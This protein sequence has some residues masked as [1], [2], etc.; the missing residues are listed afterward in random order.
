MLA[1][2]LVLL[3]LSVNLDVCLSFPAAFDSLYSDHGPGP[4]WNQSCGPCDPDLCPPTRGC[5]AGLVL[6]RC[7][8][9]EECGNREGQS[10]DPEHRGGLHGLC[11]SGLRCQADPGGRAGWEDEDDE[12]D[13]CVCEDQEP[14]CGSDGTTYTNRCQLMEAASSTHGL[15]GTRSGPC[16]TVPLFKRPPFSA[17]HSRDSSVVFLCEVFAFPMAVIQWKKEGQDVVL[18]GDDPHISVQSRGGPLKF[19]LSSW[20]QIEGAEPEDSGTYYCIAKNEL[21]VASASA[22]LAVMGEDSSSSMSSVSE[23]QELIDGTDYDTHTDVY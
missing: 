6:D 19:E 15:T 3:G 20:L 11:G 17:L 21:G 8:C 1:L 7:G 2:V 5:R 18:P 22:V 13:V 23:M 12:E 9:C 10:C 4:G 16:S 14:V